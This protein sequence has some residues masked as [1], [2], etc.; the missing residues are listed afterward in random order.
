M[1]EAAFQRTADIAK[2]FGV[3]K[4]APRPRRLPHRPRRR[5]PSTELEAEGVDVN[6]ADWK[7]ETVEGHAPRAAK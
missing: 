5:P 4:K 3:I 6:G 7:K 1:D 2:Q